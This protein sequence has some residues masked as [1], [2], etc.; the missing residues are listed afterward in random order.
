VLEG[1]ITNHRAKFGIALSQAEWVPF[2]FFFAWMGIT[3]H[4]VT[5]RCKLVFAATYLLQLRRSFLLFFFGFRN[6]HNTIA[7]AAETKS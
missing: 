7:C 1:P 5:C 3:L 4:S 2:R 6:L